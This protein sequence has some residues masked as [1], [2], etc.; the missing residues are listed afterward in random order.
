MSKNHIIIKSG[1]VLE[2]LSRAKTFAF[3]KTGTLTR[4]QLVIDRIVPE[5]GI[6]KDE[7]QILAASVEQASS[8]IIAT[9]LV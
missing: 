4:N 5:T 2:K 6:D 7:L 9:S 3:D 8:H 1:T